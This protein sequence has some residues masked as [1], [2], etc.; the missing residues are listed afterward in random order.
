MLVVVVLGALGVLQVLVALG[1]PLGRFVWG[2]GHDVLPARLRVGSA[3]SVA[4]YAGMAVV[5]LDRSGLVTVLPDGFARAATWV[6]VG[7]FAVGVLLN[8]VSRSRAE[9]RTM[10]P[11]C[12]VLALLTAAVATA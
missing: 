3:V 6:L 1:A 10:A 7:Y 4:L 9:A 12:L 11:T 8:A 2:G 5:V